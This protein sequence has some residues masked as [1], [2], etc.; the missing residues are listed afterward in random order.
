M[1]CDGSA[2]LVYM[3]QCIE[4]ICAIIDFVYSLHKQ[5]ELFRVTFWRNYLCKFVPT[6]KM[7]AYI[8][9]HALFGSHKE[10]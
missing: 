9:S 10:L 5:L 4:L 2:N 6:V 3:I 7:E 1:P 8:G